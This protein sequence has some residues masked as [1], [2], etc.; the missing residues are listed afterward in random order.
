M[1]YKSKFTGVNGWE[2]VGEQELL[3]KYARMTPEG[4]I[5]CEV[6][7]E[8]GMSA[9][10]WSKYSVAE[11][12][13]CVEMNKDAPFLQ[14]LEN[15]G[16]STDRIVWLCGDSK[17][18]DIDSALEGRKIDTLFIDGDHTYEGA[19]SDLMR[20]APLVKKYGYLIIHDVAC[21]TNKAPHPLHFAVNSALK[22]YMANEGGKL[23][24]FIESVD[25]TVV[26]ERIA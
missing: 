10:I 20:Y 4:G 9:S 15:N 25:S 17:S 2:S 24:T 1:A 5:I 7:S 18:V 14:N 21:H 22:H 6:G 13:I 16:I 3:I 23:Y 8:F 19:L 11:K 12:I 26:Y